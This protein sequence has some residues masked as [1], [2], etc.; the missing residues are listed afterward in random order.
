VAPNDKQHFVT[1]RNVLI[2]GCTSGIGEALVYLIADL[3]PNK[4]F[5]ACQSR[6]KGEAVQLQLKRK[7]IASQVL[8]GDMGT[9]AGT[10][11][12][13]NEMLYTKEPLHV[14]VSN[15][16]LWEALQNRNF[17]VSVNRQEHQ[18]PGFHS[19]LVTNYL[20]TVI[21]CTALKP[22]LE[23]SAPSRIVI[24]GSFTHMDVSK[25]KANL[26]TLNNHMLTNGKVA[27]K[28]AKDEAYAQTK[29][30]QY[31][32][33]KKFVTTVDPDLAVMVYDPGHCE[34]HNDAYHLLKKTM[35]GYG[36]S[37]Y[38]AVTGNRKPEDGARVALWCADSSEGASASGKYIDFGIFGDLK[39]NAPC[40]LGF[41][42][43]HNE[44][45]ESVRDPE[46]VERLW[47]WTQK[48]LVSQQSQQQLRQRAQQEVQM[49][50]HS[51]SRSQ[52]M[53]SISNTLPS[54]LTSKPPSGQKF[55]RSRSNSRFTDG[56]DDI[57]VL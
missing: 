8:V 55:S 3:K 13:A 23:Q 50:N 46:Q 43:S 53:T 24:T 40:E 52:Q 12:I 31:M 4:I 49:Q 7:G 51:G 41:S 57:C 27:K 39:M 19:Y 36:E 11:H 33:A 48:F 37:L 42:P 26:N 9:V 2:T 56:F 30:F 16:I 20:S 17:N 29:L 45:A 35:G 22:L 25:G 18:E 44:Y 1:G 54:L 32:W 28:P 14:L 34:T 10:Q 38:N 21:L 15:A 6:S 47:T 5:L